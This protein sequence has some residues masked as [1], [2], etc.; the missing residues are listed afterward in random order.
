VITA[1]FLS[2]PSACSEVLIRWGTRV[3][4]T[5]DQYAPVDMYRGGEALAACSNFV[6]DGVGR[7][8]LCDRIEALLARIRRLRDPNSRYRRIWDVRSSTKAVFS[9][10]P[11][12]SNIKPNWPWNLWVLTGNE[13]LFSKLSQ[14][15]ISHV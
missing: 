13:S 2:A 9:G 11:E 1:T 10:R 8:C 5:S 14:S 15:E 3:Y 7:G 4:T 12:R 6:Q